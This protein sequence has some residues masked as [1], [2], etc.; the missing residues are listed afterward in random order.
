MLVCLET[1][2]NWKGETS[3]YSGFSQSRR[4]S[5]VWRVMRVRRAQ[6]KGVQKI[7]M[8]WLIHSDSCDNEQRCISWFSCWLVSK[9]KVFYCPLAQH[10]CSLTTQLIK[11]NLSILQLRSNSSSGYTGL[12]RGII[13]YH[14]STVL[15]KATCYQ[16]L[17]NI[18]IKNNITPKKKKSQR[19][20]R[21]PQLS[22]EV[23]YWE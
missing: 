1:V 2:R 22:L 11:A 4:L 23:T 20:Q 19:L 17:K 12:T 13:Y 9:K 16:I 14:Y 18:F 8:A 21:K 3:I 6:W 15:W 7:L 10:C 5:Q